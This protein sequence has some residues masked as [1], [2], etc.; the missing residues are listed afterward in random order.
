MRALAFSTILLPLGR[1]IAQ[2]RSPVVVSVHLPRRTQA[3]SKEQV[4]DVFIDHGNLGV[5]DKVSVLAI[6]CKGLFAFGHAL[7]GKEAGG[8]RCIP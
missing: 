7:D 2:V 1:R 3:I 6:G 5:D 8:T 4:E